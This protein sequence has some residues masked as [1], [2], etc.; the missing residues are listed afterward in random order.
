MPQG[1]A[2]VAL[3]SRHL[4]NEWVPRGTPTGPESTTTLLVCSALW[5]GL[6][7]VARV[8]VASLTSITWWRQPVTSNAQV[9]SSSSPLGGLAPVCD[10]SSSSF[11]E[12]CRTCDRYC[13]DNLGDWRAHVLTACS[14]WSGPYLLF[15]KDVPIVPAV[16]KE[17]P[18]A[19]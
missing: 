9:L 16:E 1:T 19:I 3:L 6:I 13:Y 10:R 7:R 17:E 18:S 5:L 14:R 12:R 4:K 8:P 2:T 11:Y 15:A